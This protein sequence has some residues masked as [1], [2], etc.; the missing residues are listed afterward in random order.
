MVFTN[1]WSVVVMV[2][3]QCCKIHSTSPR[4]CPDEKK[5]HVSNCIGNY[6]LS[7]STW[8]QKPF[9]L[10]TTTKVFDVS[11][12]QFVRSSWTHSCVP[13]RHVPCWRPSRPRKPDAHEKGNDSSNYV[14][15]PLQAIPWTYLWSS[16]PTPANRGIMPNSRRGK[17]F[18][19]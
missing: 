2:S 14:W 9:S 18:E 4:I 12:S 13:V 11:W 10:G 3:V 16:T 19:N 7:T 1:M 17:G 8:N 6:P 5:S 15:T